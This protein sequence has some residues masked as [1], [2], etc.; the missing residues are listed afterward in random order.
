M[1]EPEFVTDERLPLIQNYEPDIDDSVY[2]DTQ[3]TQEKDTQ[4][5]SFAQQDETPRRRPISDTR[6]RLKADMIESLFRH[7][8]WEI[9]ENMIDLHLDRYKIEQENGQTIISFKKRWQMVQLNIQ[10]NRRVQ[11][12]KFHRENN[13]QYPPEN[14]RH[15]HT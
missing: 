2:E 9:D 5:T 14:P 6:N 7:M 4:E 8:G 13:D 15:L 1:I 11:R 3:E 12:E 10:M